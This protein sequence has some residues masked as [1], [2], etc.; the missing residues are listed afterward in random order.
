MIK[1]LKKNMRLF[2]IIQSFSDQLIYFVVQFGEA[3]KEKE[4]LT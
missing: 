1:N 3:E 4:V 2:Y